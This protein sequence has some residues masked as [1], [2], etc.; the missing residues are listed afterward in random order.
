MGKSKLSPV[1]NCILRVLEEAGEESL[2]TIEATLLSRG[3]EEE[4][5]Q[6]EALGD[7]EPLGFISRTGSEIALTERG[8]YALTY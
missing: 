6:R 1:Q 7:L 8:A 5:L 2:A 3:Y 4:N